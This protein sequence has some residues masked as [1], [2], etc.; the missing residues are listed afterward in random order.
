MDGAGRQ[1]LVRARFRRIDRR[2]Q[3]ADPDHAV[4]YRGVGRAARLLSQLRRRPPAAAAEQLAR[5][6]LPHV[7]HQRGLERDRPLHAR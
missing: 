5:H 4:G 6:R 2:L 3:G 1:S 7:R